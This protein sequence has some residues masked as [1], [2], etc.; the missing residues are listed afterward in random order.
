MPSCQQQTGAEFLGCSKVPAP[1]LLHKA[2][3]N[4]C[5]RRLSSKS[6][7]CNSTRF[8]GL[9]VSSSLP[10]VGTEQGLSAPN[11][12]NQQK[13]SSFSRTPNLR[14][15]CEV[16]CVYTSLRFLNLFYLAGGKVSS[17]LSNE[18][19]VMDNNLEQKSFSKIQS[20]LL[21][22]KSH[23]CKK[24]RLRYIAMFLVFVLEH[25]QPRVLEHLRH[26]E[27]HC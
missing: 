10:N 22:I 11:S 20:P 18:A 6:C 24:S 17:E 1:K 19:I 9:K 4:L 13:N 7:F 26:L 21:G 15:R 5:S 27:H 14:V 3:N 8:S 25:A 16:Y 23:A 12:T 2:K